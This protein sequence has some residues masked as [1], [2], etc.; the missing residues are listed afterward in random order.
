M[1]TIFII[2]IIL[3]S[4]SCD[5]EKKDNDYS[6]TPTC[7]ES[8]VCTKDGRCIPKDDKCENCK[9]WESCQENECVLLENR[10][11]DHSNCIDDKICDESH[12]CV[13]DDGKFCIE[14][15]CS[16]SEVCNEEKKE[17]LSQTGKCTD[18]NSCEDGFSCINSYCEKDGVISTTIQE[19][20]TEP[21][22]LEKTVQ[23]TGVVSAV[24]LSQTRNKKG[25]YI[26]NDIIKHSG[27]YIYFTT[28]GESDIKIGDR[29]K[30]TGVLDREFTGARVRTKI[31]EITTLSSGEFPYEK[32][33]IDY[34]SNDA[35]DY[36]SMLISVILEKRFNLR[37]FLEQHVV[38]R[39]ELNNAIYV[40][41]TI[42]WLNHLS[43]NIK[44][45]KLEGIL[46]NYQD[47]LRVL[48]RSESEIQISTPLCEPSCKEWEACL[49]RN[50]CTL[51]YS[52]CE[53]NEDCSNG[54]N[55][56]TETHWCEQTSGLENGEFEIWESGK[57]VG[58]L[59]G[60]ALRVSREENK[61]YQT[62]YAARVTRYDESGTANINFL[63]PKIAVDYQK[64]YKLSLFVLDNDYDVD[65]RI[66]YEAYNI[67]D[68][69]IG[70]GIP[71][72]NDGLTKNID[73]WVELTYSTNFINGG[74]I[75]RGPVEDLAYIR[76][77]IR[78]NKGH[79][80]VIDGEPLDDTLPANYE[81]SGTGDIYID[82]L[83][84]ESL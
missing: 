54:Q 59:P 46:E 38:F 66:Y 82:T 1:K 81:P 61:K 71:P 68:T 75:W 29:I 28:A 25:V 15:R 23:I 70:S 34:F 13:V 80:N 32:V 77:G 11:N 74:E 41:D 8:E 36:E 17:C 14:N 16:I 37:E 79:N 48:P 45:E 44:L 47:Y 56:N 40:K 5:T 24:A 33:K 4:L 39:D 18:D 58:Y 72:S 7:K 31:E 2:L 60:S 27:V 67:Y 62:N 49:D 53:S 21:L 83:T 20:Q 26:Q 73:N 64:N 52:R 9:E 69:K 76:F 19:I 42:S 50:S 78:I 84:I 35:K 57:A 65:C 51:D 6:C 22:L 10:C 55:C 30:V 43:L 12:N 63:S 3:L